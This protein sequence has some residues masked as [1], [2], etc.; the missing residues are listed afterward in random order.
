MESEVKME[1]ISLDEQILTSFNNSSDDS[2]FT[3]SFDET[4][5]PDNQSVVNRRSGLFSITHILKNKNKSPAKSGFDTKG[6][7]LFV[8]YL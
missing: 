4:D 6:K 7:F 2:W 8:Y 1:Q 5:N 3:A